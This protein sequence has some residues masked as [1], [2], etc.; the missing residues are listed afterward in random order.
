MAMQV[1]S[2]PQ[3]THTFLLIYTQR[4]AK[5]EKEEAWVLIK[6]KKSLDYFFLSSFFFFF[7]DAGR[8]GLDVLDQL[9]ESGLDSL[10]V[11]SGHTSFYGYSLFL[12]SC[13]AFNG[14]TKESQGALALATTTTT[15]TA[16]DVACPATR[17]EFCSLDFARTSFN[18][19]TRIRSILL[20]GKYIFFF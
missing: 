9:I 2:P 7:P 4:K 13:C 17:F 19:A 3:H 6:W 18:A 20:W 16:I 14:G 12:L 1:P 5:K 10:C 8:R 15:T 11:C